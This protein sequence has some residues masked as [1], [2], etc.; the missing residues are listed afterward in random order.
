[1]KTKGITSG[2]YLEKKPKK[3]SDLPMCPTCKKCKD[4][5]M[6]QNRKNL[7]N[8]EICKKCTNK[9]NCE[10]FYHYLRG[11]ALLTIGKDIETRE[12]IRKLFTGDTEEEA[13]ESLYK[14]KIAMKESGND[15]D[16]IIKK[17]TKSIIDIGQ[18]IE[19][20]KFRKGKTK[21]NAYRTNMATLN[22][23]KSNSFANIPI[24]KVKK[25]KLK[26]FW[27]RKESN[28]IQL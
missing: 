17:T 23:L 27:K 12:P 13:L 19:D 11:R 20:A 16:N 1:M 7:K 9:E 18:E 25:V 24:D 15:L 14:Y 8:C 6:C 5:S 21:G 3:K 10:K 2:V 4:R 22:R 26:T 28:L